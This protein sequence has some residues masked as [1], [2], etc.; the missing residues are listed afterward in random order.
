VHAPVAEDARQDREGRHRHRRAEEQREGQHPVDV[1]GTGEPQREHHAEPERQHDRP[2]RDGDRDPLAVTDERPVQLV[3]D[4]EHEQHQADIG[5]AA[6]RR[7]DIGGEQ[8]VGQ[9]RAEQRRSDEDACGDLADHLRLSDAAG[10]Q[11]EQPGE[12]DHDGQREQEPADQVG[13][14]GATTWSSRSLTSAAVGRSAAEVRQ[15]PTSAASGPVRVAAIRGGVEI[16][17][18]RASSASLAGRSP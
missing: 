8:P 13:A 9:R 17:R 18:R 7:S 2:E 6:Q 10:E 16:T 5:K 14:H 3:P 4:D 15:S 1:V 12:R 11:P